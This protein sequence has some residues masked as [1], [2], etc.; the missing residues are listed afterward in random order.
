MYC[1]IIIKY[2]TSFFTYIPMVPDKTQ[3]MEQSFPM[4][5]LLMLSTGTN[6]SCLYRFIGLHIANKELDWICEVSFLSSH[7]TTKV[8]LTRDNQKLESWIEHVG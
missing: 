8:N 3:E 6:S 1:N 5:G 2:T 4:R 7:Q